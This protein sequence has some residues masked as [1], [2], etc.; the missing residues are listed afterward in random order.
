MPNYQKTIIYRIP[1]GD[2]NYYGHTT[3]PLYKRKGKHKEAY[4]SS[5]NNRLNR[6]VYKAMRDVGMT[7][8]DIELVWVEDFPC[9]NVNQARARERYWV[10]GYGTLNMK[11]PNRSY[12]ENKRDKYA[13]DEEWRMKEQRRSQQYFSERYA[14]DEDWRKKKNE[15]KREKVECD[16]CGKEMSRNSLSRHKQNICKKQMP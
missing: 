11:V 13:N 7:G 2:D 4:K 14:N 1:V 10:E 6:K 5:Y 16:M 8:N 3:E 9:D 15:W 12:N